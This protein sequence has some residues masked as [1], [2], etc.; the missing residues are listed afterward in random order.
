AA[1]GEADQV[2]LAGHFR[3]TVSAD[4]TTAERV[5]ALAQSF[6][7]TSSKGSRLP[8]GAEPVALYFNQIVSNKLV[9]TLI[10]TANLAKKPIYVATPDRKMSVVGVGEMRVDTSKASDKSAAGAARQATGR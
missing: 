3:V 1:T 7:V 2:V 9:E 5:D 6:V 10:Y 4:G 8:E